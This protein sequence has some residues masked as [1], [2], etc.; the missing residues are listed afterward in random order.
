MSD[1]RIHTAIDTL[2][3]LM[4]SAPPI[5]GWVLDYEA[6]QQHVDAQAMTSIT[7]PILIFDAEEW[8]EAARSSNRR[9]ER[10]MIRVVLGARINKLTDPV[11]DQ[12]DRLSEQLR[13]WFGDREFTGGRILTIEQPEIVDR[14]QLRTPGVYVTSFE[15][16]VELLA[17]TAAA[18][19][20][21]IPP[22]LLT[23]AR[24]AVWEAIENWTWPEGFE[25]QRL[26]KSDADAEE[27]LL[28]GKPSLGELPALAVDWQPF[29]AE[30]VLNILQKIPAVIRLQ[31]WLP[32]SS[33]TLA[34]TIG[35]ELLAAVCRSKPE[36]S[37]VTYVRQ[38]IGHLPRP[39]GPCLIQGVSLPGADDRKVLQVTLSI[40]LPIYLDLYHAGSP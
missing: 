13:D 3:D 30:D 29:T 23:A 9:L 18:P 2:V 34:E 17:G 1:S 10:Y 7:T 35:Q 22:A 11:I 14:S 21:I 40:G 28:R 8:T 24:L 26:F 36:E 16:E 25:W 19:I 31:A 33:L 6:A 12:L 39:L 4:E 15:I 38:A 27:L 32:A 20:S 5:G 37:S